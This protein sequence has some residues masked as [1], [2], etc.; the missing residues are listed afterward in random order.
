M[1][2]Y[3]SID[4]ETTGL[5]PENDQILEFA[6]VVWK[7]YGPI[8]EQP[9]FHRVIYHD[10]VS[11]SPMAMSMNAKLLEKIARGEGSSLVD[12][13]KDFSKFLD[14]HFDP[15][16]KI[17]PLGFNVGQFDMAFLRR[18]ISFPSFRFLHRCLEVGSL[19][20]GPDGIP[21]SSDLYSC[22]HEALDDARNA[23]ELARR[24][25]VYNF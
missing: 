21:A 23:L 2:K 11:G 24:V 10:R 16:Q 19:Y 18:C 17:H 25:T 12:T 15:G 4:I 6:A 20:A 22:S 9:Y 8:L 3:I 5:D 13:F 14:D 1:F 7:D